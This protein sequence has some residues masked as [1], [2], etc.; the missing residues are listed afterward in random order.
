MADPVE[1]TTAAHTPGPWAINQDA[2]PG[3]EWNCEI[4]CQ[5]DPDH[6]VAIMAHSNGCY[7]ERD[8]ANARL[9]AAAPELLAT[10]KALLNS[11]EI[12]DCHPEDKD[13][14]THAIERH[15]R[16]LLAKIAGIL[17]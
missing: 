12:A 15:A 7:P 1:R 11:P 3:M 5:A 16:K 10:V 8:S 17:A 13:P 9:I 14:E 6:R 4:V 2:R